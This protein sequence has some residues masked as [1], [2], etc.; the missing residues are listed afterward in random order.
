MGIKLFWFL[1]TTFFREFQ[2]EP[3]VCQ[4]KFK[5]LTEISVTVN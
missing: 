5:L 4:L 1:S 3:D 2:R